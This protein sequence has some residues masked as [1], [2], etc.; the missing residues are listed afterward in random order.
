MAIDVW[1]IQRYKTVE[2]FVNYGI[3]PTRCYFCTNIYYV[4]ILIGCRPCVR[5]EP[6]PDIWL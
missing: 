4:T 6:G 1:I 3:F 2:L 5:S